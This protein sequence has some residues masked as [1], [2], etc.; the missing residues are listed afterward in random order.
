MVHLRTNIDQKKDSEPE[1]F[2]CKLQRP[3]A[4]SNLKE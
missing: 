2:N 4:S 3:F 1:T